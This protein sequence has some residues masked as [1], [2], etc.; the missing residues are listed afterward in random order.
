MGM[1]KKFFLFF[2]F[3]GCTLSA[4]FFGWSIV[5]FNEFSTLLSYETHTND[6]SE[7]YSVEIDGNYYM[8]D[9]LEKNGAW[10]NDDL[11]NFLKISSSRG[12]L[13]LGS[14]KVNS[15]LFDKEEMTLVD[16]NLYYGKTYAS[17]NKSIMI[18]Q[19]NP[20]NA[21][22]SIST[23][24]LGTLGI[25]SKL[26]LFNKLVTPSVAYLPTDG[27][28]ET[29]LTV[30][31][32]YTTKI[33]NEICYYNSKDIDV[34]ETVLLRL[35]LDNAST[36]TEALEIIYSYDLY[37]SSDYLFDITITDSN[38]ESIKVYTE[39]KLY[40]GENLLKISSKKYDI[41]KALN[42]SEAKDSLIS[43]KSTNESFINNYTVMYNKNDKIAQY[44]SFGNNEPLV[45]VTL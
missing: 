16:N 30:S 40:L 33:Q 10:S 13:S 19:T 45:T 29:G 18:V 3:L 34:T 31:L 32:N 8:N 43:Y 22:S 12:L 21:Y 24:N 5:C 20:K 4:I 14:L 25:D 44:Y 9:F 37:L 35:I 26:N 38:G 2:T 39:E 23:V 6:D 27:M 1:L 7:I 41:N 11:T 36:I 42:I 28:N 17:E 15:L